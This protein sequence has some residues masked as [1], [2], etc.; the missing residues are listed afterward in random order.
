MDSYSVSVSTPP[1]HVVLRPV[2]AC[3]LMPWCMFLLLQ[4][5]VLWKVTGPCLCYLTC[6][7]QRLRCSHEDR[8]TP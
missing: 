2:L 7:V 3:W 4:A 8:E 5:A 6:T 1:M